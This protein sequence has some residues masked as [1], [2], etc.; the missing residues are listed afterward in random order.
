MTLRLQN[1]IA[2]ITG[3]A[4]GIG[5][6]TARLFIQ[7]GA[8]VLLTDIQ[9]SVGQ[10]LATSLGKQAYYA[11]LDVQEE[12]EWIKLSAYIHEQW[13]RLD[14]LFNNAGVTGIDK[15]FGPQDP[16]HCSLS[17]WQAIHRINLDSIFL[18]C[19]YGIELMKAQGG[20]MINMASR[21]GIVGIPGAAAYASSKAAI[22]NHSRSVAL[23]CAQ[24]QYAIR[25][26]VLLPGAILTPL[27][28]SMLGKT[29]EEREIHIREIASGIPLGHMG[30]PIDV[31]YAAL[32]LATD[33]SR[34][35]T[36]ASIT[37]DGGILA[38]SA[39]SPK[40]NK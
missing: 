19:K 38:G 30:E 32:Y 12:S 4:Q 35:M 31:A 14:V 21:S 29:P 5:A 26:N 13:G 24:K 23:Y 15:H 27:W 18:G 20:S 25:C 40:P 39:A 1:K 8:T 17:D 11:R 28:D 9:D 10:K 37:L 6:E 3:A 36:G 7:E 22:I 16:E 34:Y 33:E 2:L